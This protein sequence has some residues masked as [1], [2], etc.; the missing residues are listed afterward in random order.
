MGNNLADNKVK[1]LKQI[2]D[3]K[4]SEAD[5]ITIVPHIRTDFDAIGSA[6][7]L[8]ILILRQKKEVNI[9]INDS[10]ND[11]DQGVQKILKEIKI[12]G[13]NI[14]NY[15]EYKSKYNN[16]TNLLILTD[17]SQQS[18]IPIEE[19]II[20]NKINQE[21]IIIIDHHPYG[22]TPINVKDKYKYIFTE[23]SSTCE[24]ITKMFFLS[25]VK[26]SKEIAT[27]LYA[28]IWLD[29]NRL[30]K[31]GEINETHKWAGRLVENGA[32]IDK[33]NDLFIEDLNNNE[34]IQELL[35]KRMK[36]FTYTV[37]CLVGE[38]NKKY[39]IE[40]L[41]KVADAC[42]K[43]KIDASF[44]VGSVDNDTVSI[45]ARSKGNINAGEILKEFNGGGNI[46]S[47][48]AKIKDTVPSE[49]GKRLLKTLKPN[50]YI[51]KET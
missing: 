38:D 11:L 5:N 39:S 7:A 35:A 9:L 13:L 16:D 18:L 50:F 21:K 43:Y 6:L 40:D 1:T 25:R 32:D 20:E 19:K 31:K 28:G 17:T 41:A 22:N 24:L 12:K 45:S 23:Y 37:A 4:V 48:G 29:S 34:K 33:V 27:Y 51:D 42:L 26:F 8:Y 49:V 47:A 10:F 36:L 2:I 30:T 14:I 3:M 15:S 44:A 46:Y